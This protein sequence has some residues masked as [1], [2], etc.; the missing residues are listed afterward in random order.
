MIPKIPSCGSGLENRTNTVFEM[1]VIHG[2]AEITDH[3]VLKGAV[4]RDLIRVSGHENRRDPMSRVKQV[5]VELDPRH[6]GHV[7]VSY[8]AGRFSEET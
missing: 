2:L 3:P 1:V 8:Q 7:D 5:F 6:C 4:P